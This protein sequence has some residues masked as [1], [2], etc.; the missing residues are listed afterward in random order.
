MHVITTPASLGRKIV[1]RERELS[2]RVRVE[3]GVVVTGIEGKTG[4]L[5]PEDEDLAAVRVCDGHGT[6]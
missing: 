2:R 6:V 1:E 5:G 4:G 3:P